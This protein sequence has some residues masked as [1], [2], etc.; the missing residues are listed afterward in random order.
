VSGLE[1]AE[2]INL[3]LVGVLAGNDLGHWSVVHPAL[4]KISAGA[5]YAAER[6]IFRRYRHIMPVLVPLALVSGIVTAVIGKTSSTSF[7]L[8]VGGCVALFGW[9]L[10]V[11]SLYPLNERILGRPVDAAPPPDDEWWAIRRVWYR[12]HTIRVWLGF[13]AFAVFILSALLA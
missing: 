7:W 2:L 13:V 8:A 5:S 9:Q 10:V 11:L 1:T 3:L 4:G 6:A 12:R